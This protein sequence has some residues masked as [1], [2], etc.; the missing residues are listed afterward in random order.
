MVSPGA[1][2]ELVAAFER[3][4]RRLARAVSGLP[5]A[6]LGRRPAPQAWSV[7]EVLA[8]LADNAVVA[9]WRMRLVL[10]QD[11]PPLTPYDQDAWAW[12]Y[13]HASAQESLATL[14][15]LRR[16][17]AGL[18]RRAPASAWQKAGF[19]PEQGRRT[20][21]DLVQGQIDHLDEHVGQIA[22]IKRKI[23]S[24]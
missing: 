17:A 4:P 15:L 7:Q 13:Q 21:R 11:D 18:L 10:A 6:L 22:E 16:T 1:E 20:L 5:R 12:P 3:G 8:H 14:R 9:A 24:P 19:H 2:A 23:R